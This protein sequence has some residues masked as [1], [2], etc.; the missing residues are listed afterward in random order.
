MIV[1]ASHNN[2]E[3]LESIVEQLNNI[4]L[5][6]HKVLIIDTNSD[7]EDYK[8]KFNELKEINSHFI[9]EQLD[10]NCWDSGAYIHAYK[11]YSDNHYIF[12]QDSLTITNKNLIPIFDNFLNIYDVVPLFNFRYGY[13]NDGQ[14][15]FVEQNLSI[16]SLPEYAIFGPIFGVRKETLDKLSK[17]WLIYP[18]NKNEGCGMERR[19]S[20][21]FHLIDASKHYLEFENFNR[22]NTIFTNKKYI[23]KHFLH[24]L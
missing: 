3:L 20:L 12:L 11:N 9:F 6:N 7:N 23:D 13:E 2:I 5:N 10:Y 17:D 19:W 15:I 24:R 8:N 18:T 4:N 16:S 1:I 14:K 21:M 22:N